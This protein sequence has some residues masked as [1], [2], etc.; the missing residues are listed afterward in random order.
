MYARTVLEH[1]RAKVPIVIHGVSLN[2]GNADALNYEYL[3]K[4]KALAAELQPEWI[5]DLIS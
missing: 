3:Q 4:L 2:I 1:I 5:S